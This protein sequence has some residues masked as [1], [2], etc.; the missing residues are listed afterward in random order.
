MLLSQVISVP[1]SLCSVVEFWSK[2]LFFSEFSGNNKFS[3]ICAF[4]FSERET[5][6]RVYD[7]M[8]LVLNMQNRW[9]TRRNDRRS[10]TIPYEKKKTTNNRL[11]F[12]C[13]NPTSWMLVGVEQTWR[14]DFDSSKWD[15]S[16]VFI[17]SGW[18][19]IK[20]RICEN[21]AQHTLP[22][23]YDKERFTTAKKKIIYTFVNG[24]SVAVPI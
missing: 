22:S 15:Y 20:H 18:M 12:R 9:G 2:L 11:I 10:I 7:S 5:C 23:L 3:C 21:D 17:C 13:Q 19:R 14:M 8:I 6:T 1:H 24:I 4:K 16:R